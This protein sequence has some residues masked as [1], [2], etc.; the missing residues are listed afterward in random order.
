MI[1]DFP[2]STVAFTIKIHVG[3]FDLIRNDSG[4]RHLR[5][6]LELIVH[7]AIIE[8]LLLTLHNT[9]D[10]LIVVFQCRS[11]SFQEEE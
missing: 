3:A 4:L 10:R 6:S 8:L 2:E 11:I 5:F 1:L 9:L 7:V